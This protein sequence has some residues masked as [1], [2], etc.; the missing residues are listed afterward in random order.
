MKGIIRKFNKGLP[1]HLQQDRCWGFRVSLV[2][3]CLVWLFSVGFLSPVRANSGSLFLS[4][5]SESFV[6]GDTFQVQVKVDTADIPINA[7]RVS[8]YF[9]QDK[10]EVLN[11]SKED[12]IFTLWPQEPIFS[13]A[14]GKISLSGGLPHP[15]FNW[16]GNIVTINFKTRQKGIVNLSF[17]DSNVL[18]DDGRGTDIL[19]FIKEAKYYIKETTKDQESKSQALIEEVLLPQIF[20][21]TNP[22]E[23]QWYNNES[24]RF[25]WELNPEITGVSFILD[26]NPETIPDERSE[27][28]EQSKTYEN[29][30]DGIW[31]FHLRLLNETGWGPASHYKVQID[32]KPPYP[33]EIIIDNKGDPTN[34]NPNLYFETTDDTSGIQYYKFRV[35]DQDFLNL[36]LAQV[37]PLSLSNLSPG[38]HYVLIRASDK[39]GNNVETKTV[40]DVEPIES[41]QITVWP[42]FHISGDQIFYIEGTSLPGVEVTIFLK[43]N[44]KEI[45]RWK[46][47]AN[48]DGGWSLS[49][50]ELIKTGNYLLSAQ[51]KDQRGA[52]STLSEVR[53]IKVLLSGISL[54]FYLVSFKTLVLILSIVL[55]VCVII[56]LYLI[57]RAKKGKRIL[58]KETQEVKETVD[59]VFNALRK[60]IEERLEMFDSQKGFSKKEREVCEELKKALYVSEKYI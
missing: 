10:L 9:P 41:P 59:K 7:A 36:M 6:V 45:K 19:V 56:A 27:G 39:A 34:P 47:L 42:Q 49:T 43:E 24:P 15:G 37:N 51:A 22:Q 3:F 11:I 33:F 18:A 32:T 29:V 57:F 4:P 26:K 60:E 46:T 44:D 1:P 30:E 5:L 25:Q 38:N 8:I 20:S 35:D 13:N 40:I 17:G 52:I 16:E 54:G 23:N 2:I 58:Q 31:Y 21:P 50:K 12:S 53:Q 14:S 48:G 28:R 55:I